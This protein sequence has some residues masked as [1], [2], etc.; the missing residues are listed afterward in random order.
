MIRMREHLVCPFLIASLLLSFINL[1]VS[2]ED[3]NCAD[4]NNHRNNPIGM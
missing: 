4:T 3:V 2:A 1:P